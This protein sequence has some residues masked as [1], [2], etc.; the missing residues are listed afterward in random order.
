MYVVFSKVFH[1]S[2]PQIPHLQMV[3]GDKYGDDQGP[4]QQYFHL[5]LGSQNPSCSLVSMCPPLW[6]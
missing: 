2:G 6:D 3:V 5:L 4:I 1:L